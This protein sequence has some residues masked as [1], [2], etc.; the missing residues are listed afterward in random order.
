MNY[1]QKVSI[2]VKNYFFPEQGGKI[3]ISQK[4]SES[5]WFIELFRG[6]AGFG[7][8]ENVTEKEIRDSYGSNPYFFMVIDRLSSIGAALPRKLIDTDTGEEI[9]NPNSEQKSLSDLLQNPSKNEQ[10]YEFYYKCLV[11][12][13]LGDLYLYKEEENTLPA[14]LKI[15]TT[16]S[17]TIQE[18]RIGSVESYSFTYFDDTITNA[19]PT[20]VLHLKRP[21][22]ICDSH[23]GFNTATPTTPLWA[24]SNEIFK[25]GY[26]LHKNKGI[27]GILHG[28]GNASV[29][30]PKEQD[31]LQNHYDKA[32][33]NNANLGRVKVSKTEMGYLQM[34][35]N[36][37]DLKSVEMNLDLL[38]ATC[39]TFNVASQLF[40]DT[41]ASTY[42][43]MEQ[44]EKAMY[45]NAI[46]PIVRRLDKALNYW[47]VG[48]KTYCFKVNEK[49]IAILQ[50]D[51]TPLIQ[52]A[53]A[54][55]NSGLITLEEA[56]TMID[57][58]MKEVPTEL[59]KNQTEENTVNTQENEE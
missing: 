32:F 42:S 43:N 24:T 28:K 7:F 36:P 25:S 46:L 11:N 50:E 29:M 22:V 33:G 18:D 5:K 54:M 20:K 52:N 57:A 15:P 59:I 16:T 53:I 6:F 14:S 58:D 47:L 38:R 30:T 31:T 40:G 9:T 1:L 35:V 49:E 44:A 8:K 10:M 23:Y 13:Y 2:Q 56:R 19:D 26:H 55:Y 3:S 21:N 4:T 41:A 39:A 48:D 17:V 12:L 37:A 45:V 51:K 34:G 27:Q